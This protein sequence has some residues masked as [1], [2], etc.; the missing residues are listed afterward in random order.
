MATSF[1]ISIN[2]PCA[3]NWSNMQA[4]TG[5]RFC[6]SCQKSVTDFTQ[7]SD[8]D[9]QDWFAKNESQS[10]GRFKPEQINRLINVKSNFSIGRFKPGL[11]AT[12]L[13]AFL[14]FPKVGNAINK[15]WPTHQTEAKKFGL[16]KIASPLENDSITVKGKVINSEESLP[17]VGGSVRIKGT[18]V[19]TV[20]DKEGNFELKVSR[21]QIKNGLIL[22]SIYL[23]FETRRLKVN[24]KKSESITITMK[25]SY[26]ILGGFGVIKTPTLLN[27]LTRFLNG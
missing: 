11:I 7:F 18:T 21:N 17:I 27:K 6:D 20:T 12:S 13:V 3:E 9:L 19:T 26:A 23:G 14:S 25:M 16:E 22:E 15:S 5:E 1:I 2:N 8:R 10:C 24:L 4:G